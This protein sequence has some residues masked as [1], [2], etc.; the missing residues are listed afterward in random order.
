M[1]LHY[2]IESM[3]LHGDNACKYHGFEKYNPLTD[4]KEPAMFWLYEEQSYKL[5]ANHKGKKYIFWH[6]QDVMGLMRMF[7]K[8]IP[9]VRD[10]SIIHV[11][12][13]E[14]LRDELA[15]VGIYAL[16]RPI[17]W[18][19]ASK[20]VPSERLTRDCYMTANKGRGVEYGEMIM[21]KICVCFGIRMFVSPNMIIN[22]K[23]SIKCK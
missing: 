21:N 5:L 22:P 2:N 1:K 19:D 18:G 20:Y 17:F 23:Q 8:Y 6:N 9:V 7:S 12:H 10:Q 3:G 11:C 15:S 4:L 16:I 14:L 13:N